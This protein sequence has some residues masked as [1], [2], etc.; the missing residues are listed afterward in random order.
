MFLNEECW[1]KSRESYCVSS[2]CSKYC[3]P[4]SFDKVI[5]FTLKYSGTWFRSRLT[6][7]IKYERIVRCTRGNK[8]SVRTSIRT[9]YMIA[10]SYLTLVFTNTT[11]VHFVILGNTEEE[12]RGKYHYS[13]KYTRVI[14]WCSTTYLFYVGPMDSLTLF[15]GE[16]D[17]G[18][19][20]VSWTLCSL[21]ICK[22]YN[23]VTLD[24]N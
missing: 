24:S 13:L 14:N 16:V 20:G 21:L 19:L 7:H 3:Q 1:I 11:K 17:W 10:S 5:R 22:R 18:W 9:R 8:G 6:F 2:K 23:S 15:G 12:G 4:Q